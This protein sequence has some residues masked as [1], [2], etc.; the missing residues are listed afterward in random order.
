[1]AAG[2]PP[3]ARN[4]IFINGDGMGAA[5]LEAGRLV[6]AGPVG[7][8]I[9]RLEVR[10]RVRS[11][12]PRGGDA[13]VTD[14]AAAAT[15]WSTGFRTSN[16]AV[17]V[18]ARGRPLPTFGREAKA[19]GKATGLVTTTAVTDATPAAFFA[20]VADRGLSERIARQYVDAGGPDVVLGGGRNIW[21]GDLLDR[22][23]AA[24]YG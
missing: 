21:T 7:L 16:G 4:V 23:R 12:S 5:Q 6:F 11:G 13:T 17:G 24:G 14:S 18:D 9:D 22:A 3:Q 8:E 15:A 2:V 20:S 1:M 10:G 19:A